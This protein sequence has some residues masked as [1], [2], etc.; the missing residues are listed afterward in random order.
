MTTLCRMSHRLS[1][2]TKKMALAR[3]LPNAL[4]I[5]SLRVTAGSAAAEMRPVIGRFEARGRGERQMRER[6]RGCT[7]EME[8]KRGVGRARGER[9]EEKDK[10]MEKGSMTARD[11]GIEGKYKQRTAYL[12]E[13]T[14]G[15]DGQITSQ[16]E[17]ELNEWE[18]VR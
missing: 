7:C 18:N 16:R 9:G 11:K 10:E 6:V 5:N 1:D 15:K 3:P 2:V 17:K 13:R 12:R 14:G 4:R 8:T